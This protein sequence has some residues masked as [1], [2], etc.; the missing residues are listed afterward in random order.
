MA[1]L[2]SWRSVPLLLLLLNIWA[3]P[4]PALAPPPSAISSFPTP[5]DRSALQRFLGMVN[6]YRKFICGAALLLRLLKDALRDPK[7]PEMDS[8]FPTAKTALVSIPALIHPDSS[9]K[10]SIAVDASDSHVGAVFQP[11]VCGSW[12][13]LAFFS[14]I[15]VDLM[16]P[17]PSSRGFTYLFTILD[18]TSRWPEAVPLASISA[19][20][21]ARA[22]ISGRTLRFGVPAKMTSDRGAQ[23]TSSIW[24]IL[25]SLLNT[26]C[27]RKFPSSIQRP[28]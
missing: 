7:S 16:G 14:H 6:F 28:C 3:T 22:L 11:L 25:C 23:F 2:S 27:S 12:A 1:S 5:A 20:D 10:I 8:S 26:T 17:L 13:P 15:Y 4:S 21:F 24:D 19:A 18:R 9:A